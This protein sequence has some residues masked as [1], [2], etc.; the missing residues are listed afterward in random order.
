MKYIIVELANHWGVPGPPQPP[1]SAS[2]RGRLPP[3]TGVPPGRTAGGHRCGSQAGS[4]RTTGAT[5][6]Q[7]GEATNGAGERRPLSAPHGDG[8]GDVAPLA[9]IS[10]DKVGCHWPIYKVRPPPLSPLTALPLPG[11]RMET[12]VVERQPG[13]WHYD[14][15][16]V[17][18]R[19]SQ[20]RSQDLAIGGG[21]PAMVA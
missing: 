14:R 5:A 16:K 2:V 21:Q 19:A 13:G 9:P 20:G 8:R 15:M 18:V 11:W 17:R 10:T 3:A 6:R 7:G 12:P 4:R 1:P